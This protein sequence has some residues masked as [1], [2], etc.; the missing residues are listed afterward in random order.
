MKWNR[1]LS[2]IT[3]IVAMLSVATADVQAGCGCD[4]PSP[5]PQ[6]VLP[7]FGSPGD[8]IVLTGSGFSTEKDGNEVEF[9]RSFAVKVAATDAEHIRV[10]VP[11]SKFGKEQSVVGPMAIRVKTGNQVTA[12]Y[13][14]DL[15]TYLPRA[16]VLEESQG[17][18]MFLGFPL[19]V[20]SSG[21]LNIPID[22]SGITAATNF[23]VY[24]R[25]LPLDFDANDVIIY[26]K[27]GFNLNLFTLNVEGIEKQ[28]GDWYGAQV[29]GT[30]DSDSSDLLSYWRHDFVAYK[31]A[32]SPGGAY[33]EEAGGVHP[34]GTLHVDHDRLNVAIS[35]M[36]RD[37]RDPENVDKMT[38]L[39]PGKVL[40]AEVHILQL[41]TEDPFAFEHLTAEQQQALSVYK[42]ATPLTGGFLTLTESEAGKY[43]FTLPKI[44]S[45]DSDGHSSDHNH[46][47]D[48]NDKH[49]HDHHD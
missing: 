31:A 48:H 12:E 16:I 25:N 38:Y 37:P 44:F 21:V 28:W 19:A 41:Q 43:S 49:H 46:H 40:W 39:E 42:L 24:I 18:Y 5:C 45:K 1:A 13:S 7:A 32:H 29:L 30:I 4:H 20:D 17:H 6:P 2:L 8:T 22:L 9:G 27:D 10:Q 15:F 33:Y 11:G 34:D 23:A 26:N 14:S 36:L 35:G 47:H 3:L